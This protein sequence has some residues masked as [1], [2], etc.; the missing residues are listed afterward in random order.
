M[1]QNKEGV[2]TDLEAKKAA[3]PLTESLGRALDEARVEH[4]E[5]ALL[6]FQIDSVD[7]TIRDLQ[8]RIEKLS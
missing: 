5:L 3:E 6:Y 4:K 8:A 1:D 7:R 2:R